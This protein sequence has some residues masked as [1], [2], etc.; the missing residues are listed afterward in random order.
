MNDYANILNQIDEA[1]G[2][3]IELLDHEAE[4]LERHPVDIEALLQTCEHK[5]S[6]MV[7]L[8]QLERARSALLE[9][10]GLNTD[11]A[12]GDRVAIKLELNE[13][14]Q[15]VIERTEAAAQRN[16]LNGFVIGRRLDFHSRALNFLQ[17]A[18]GMTMYGPN[19]RQ[20][21]LGRS[22]THLVG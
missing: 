18:A 13:L 20:H 15:R 7:R 5:G 12:T 3:F 2:R 9:S 19:G 1:L 14:W 22:S 21:H 8:D 10:R 16:R 11:R 17:T 6:A 4:L